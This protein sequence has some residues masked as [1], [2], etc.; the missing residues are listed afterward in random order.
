MLS[1]MAV[2]ASVFDRTNTKVELEVITYES[3]RDLQRAY[4]KVTGD[5]VGALETEAFAQWNE[6]VEE[7]E[8]RC[9]VHIRD[10]LP[11][12]DLS[13]EIKHCLK[14]EFHR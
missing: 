14:G 13:H 1:S 9:T 2:D 7:G 3:K 6:D 5:T 8:Y 10:K 11:M 4:R 12:D